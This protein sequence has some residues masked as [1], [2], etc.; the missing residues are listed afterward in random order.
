MQPVLLDPSEEGLHHSIEKYSGTIKAYSDV[1]TYRGYRI[2]E[3]DKEACDC[4]TIIWDKNAGLIGYE[5]SSTSDGKDL[6]Q[7]WDGK[8]VKSEDGRLIID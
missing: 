3:K 5:S 1:V 4:I 7:I 6:F 2:P 8:T